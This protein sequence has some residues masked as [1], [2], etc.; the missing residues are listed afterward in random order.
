MAS[1]QGHTDSVEAVVWAGD[2]SIFSASRDRTIKL[3]RRAEHDGKARDTCRAS[4]Q[5]NSHTPRAIRHTR[6]RDLR[7]GSKVHICFL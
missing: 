5:N 3:W 4:C 2:G 1:L 6:E 7:L